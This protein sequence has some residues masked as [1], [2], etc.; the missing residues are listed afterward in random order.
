MENSWGGKF[1]FYPMEN[2][3]QSSIQSIS[4]EQ[5]LCVS[6]VLA[7]GYTMMN[8][9]NIFP[10]L[11]ELLAWTNIRNVIETSEQ[12]TNGKSKICVCSPAQ[13]LTRSHLTSESRKREL[14]YLFTKLH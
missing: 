3:K 9:T 13:P 1:G 2:K 11:M 14:S 6:T 7:S 10:T 4:N 5:L 12:K 8:K